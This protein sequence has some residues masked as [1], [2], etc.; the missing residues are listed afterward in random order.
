M[1]LLTYWP[2]K[3]EVDRCIK[4]EAE[5]VSDEVLLA[6]HQEFPLAYSKVGPDGRV[7]TDSRQLAS[8]DDFLRY[9]LGSALKAV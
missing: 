6:V 3:E 1:S 4:S 7:V 8:E 9:F 2:E 5:T